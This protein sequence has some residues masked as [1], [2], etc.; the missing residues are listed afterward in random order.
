MLCESKID[1]T[2]RL[3]NE[4]RW[5]EASEFRDECRQALQDQGTR[6]RDANQQA[7]AM[8]AKEFP[9]LTATQ[10]EWRRACEY[11]VMAEFP[12][13]ADGVDAESEP[14]M[15]VIWWLWGHSLARLCRYRAEDFDG[16]CIVA[17]R[18]ITSPASP[19]GIEPL[20]AVALHD[21]FGFLFNVVARKFKAAVERIATTGGDQD[22]AD[23]L[24]AAVELVAR[25]RRIELR[26][27]P[28]LGD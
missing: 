9:P 1:L 23:E 3:R 13:S 2:D 8:M 22:V 12:P 18:M 15:N 26:Y 19:P 24:A 6:R 5:A 7:W 20:A 21:P 16:A 25:I 10:V 27:I 28:E 14:P 17:H 11:L 4:G